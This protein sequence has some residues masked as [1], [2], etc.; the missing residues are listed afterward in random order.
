MKPL[1]H[2]HHHLL[3]KLTAAFFVLV[4]A[5]FGF[6]QAVHVHEALAGQASPTTHCSLCVV[7]HSAA[8]VTPVN[9]VPLPVAASALLVAA[10]PQLESQLHVASSFIRPPPQSL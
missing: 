10:A 9:A 6:V 1:P 3:K 4:V 2:M 8:V 7:A 5:G